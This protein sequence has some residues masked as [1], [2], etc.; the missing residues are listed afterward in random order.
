[1]VL[2]LS[3]VYLLSF[4]LI[5]LYDGSIPNLCSITSLRIL[6]MSDICQCVDI[7]IVMEKSDEHEFLFSIKACAD[8]ELLVRVA[9]ISHY[10]FVLSPLLFVIRQLIGGLLIG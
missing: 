6:S 2:S 7:K 8:P 4:C 5:G 9:V 10:L 3:E 1:M